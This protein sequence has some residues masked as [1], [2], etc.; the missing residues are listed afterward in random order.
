M[1]HARQ[2]YYLK[3]FTAERIVD[4]HTVDR[5][6]M[7]WS[8]PAADLQAPLPCVFRERL[9]LGSTSGSFFPSPTHHILCLRFY[10]DQSLRT[11]AAV[12]GRIKSLICTQ[13][14]GDRVG[15]CNR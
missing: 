5:N 1:V 4:I 10:A 14:V 15:L 13:Q 7:N 9:V 8:K 6:R 11:W 2:R 12:E 3:L